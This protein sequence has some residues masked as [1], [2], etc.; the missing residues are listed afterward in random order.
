M[1]KIV[2][3]IF[4]FFS[5][6]GLFAGNNLLFSF[7]GQSY[8]QRGVLT[9]DDREFAITVYVVSTADK[10]KMIMESQAGRL[11]HIELDSLGDVIVC[12]GGKFFPKSFVER[13]V[14]PNFRA[15]MGFTKFFNQPL[16]YLKN[17]KVCEIHYDDVAI[18]FCDNLNTSPNNLACVEIVSPSYKVDLNFVS[19]ISKR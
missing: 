15:I 14:L 8:I 1:K 13:F 2:A 5:A 6:V 11:A 3:G 12:E 18:N 19:R 9:F 4:L 16:M 17:G 7:A 10:K